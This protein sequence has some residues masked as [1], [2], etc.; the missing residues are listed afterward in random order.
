M[1]SF[2]NNTF[3][4]YFKRIVQ[5]GQ[6]SNT[7]VDTVVRRLK[8]GDDADTVIALSDD[9]LH[10]QP[11]SDDTTA[12]CTVA[13]AGGSSIFAVDTLNSKVLM[14]ASKVPPTLIK[15][16]GLYD[17]SPTAGYHYPLIANTMFVPTGATAFA[18]DNV[19]GNVQTLRLL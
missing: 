14:G 8:T 5:V 11:N 3:A 9:Q 18:G 1:A 17:F 10:I 6:T 13:N 2:L 19:W 15:E 7:G 4:S 16:M 12:A